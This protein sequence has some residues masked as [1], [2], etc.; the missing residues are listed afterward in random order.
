MT[1]GTCVWRRAVVGKVEP[2]DVA[3]LTLPIFKSTD[4]VQIQEKE[5]TLIREENAVVYID[6]P[7]KYNPLY[8]RDKYRE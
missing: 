4:K 2:N 5:H 7:E 6:P 3:T 1:T 8:Q